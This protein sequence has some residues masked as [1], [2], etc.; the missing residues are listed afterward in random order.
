MQTGLD[1]SVIFH[2]DH[3][4]NKMK[5]TSDACKKIKKQLA[6]IKFMDIQ[7]ILIVIECTADKKSVVL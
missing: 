6:S 4:M 3:L 1:A 5:N 2:T 7:K